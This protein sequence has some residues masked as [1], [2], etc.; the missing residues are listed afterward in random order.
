MHMEEK[1]WR[2]EWSKSEYKKRPKN[3]LVYREKF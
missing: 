2:S 3:E 1:N